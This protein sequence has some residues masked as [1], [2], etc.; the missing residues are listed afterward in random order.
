VPRLA[1]LRAFAVL[2]VAGSALAWPHPPGSI[3]PRMRLATLRQFALSHPQ[4]TVV[5]QWGETLVFKV[6]GKIFL[7]IS[8]DAEVIEGLSFK[9][10]PDEFDA[11]TEIDGIGQAPYLCQAPLGPRRRSR[12][13]AGGRTPPPHPPKLRSRDSE[14]PQEN[15][16]HPPHP[17]RLTRVFQAMARPQSS[18][19]ALGPRCEVRVESPVSKFQSPPPAIPSATPSS[20]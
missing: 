19:S 7:M 12:R 9:C 8:L 2:T 3:L 1:A 14:T 20:A 13:P 4:T 15:P 16:R 10:T 5:K 18:G 6:A 11:L 17:R